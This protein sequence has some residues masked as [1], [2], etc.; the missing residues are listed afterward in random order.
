MKSSRLV[1]LNP[2]IFSAFLMLAFSLG[3]TR[4]NAEPRPVAAPKKVAAQDTSAS[5]APGQSA[6]V[7]PPSI[8]TVAVITPRASVRPEQIEASGYVMHWQENHVGSEV[9]GLRLTSVLVNVGDVVKKGQVLALLNAATVEAELDAA[10][11]Q[12]VEAEAALAQATATLARA[13]RLAP[14]GGISQ[15]DLTLYETQHQTAVARRDAARAQ[16]KKQQ[17]KLGFATLVAPDDG[18]ISSCS[19]VEGAIVQAG[20]EL[21]RL[22]RQSR[23]QW[24][25]EVKGA[26][27]LKIKP[28]QN[29]TIQSPLV[30]SVKGTVRQVSPTIDRLTEKGMVYVDLP[31]ENGFKAGLMVSGVLEIGK[32]N[33]LLL[34]ATAVLQEDGRY[35]VLT[36]ASDNRLKAV[37]IE[38][39]KE[40]EGWVEVFSGLEREAR[41][42]A[43]RPS[44]LKAGDL[45]QTSEHSPSAETE[46]KKAS[47]L[48]SAERLTAVAD[49]PTSS[50]SIRQT[51]QLAT[52]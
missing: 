43:T 51:G 17:L 29:V 15:Q 16:V 47:P 4:L 39:G 25:A 31:K 33:V 35:R 38:I 44:G 50:A 11:A 13:N 1:K 19:A 48:Q 20:G 37:D 12:L 41:V 23:L 18:V 36:V 10:K 27:L 40:N 6:P 45:V 24:H 5:T 28:G 8:A 49:G 21:F 46:E 9:G 26:F 7:T 14:S 22:I 42:V 30:G 52:R 2:V 34:P 3:A 32:R